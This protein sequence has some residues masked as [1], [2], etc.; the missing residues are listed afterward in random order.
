MAATGAVDAA[1]FEQLH[2]RSVVGGERTVADGVRATS[3]GAAVGA[4]VAEEDR[5][6]DVTFGVLERV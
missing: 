5:A 3:G 2:D 1:T 6:R 4:D